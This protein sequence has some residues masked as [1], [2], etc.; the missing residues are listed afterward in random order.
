MLTTNNTV[1]EI[2]EHL[3]ALGIEYPESATKS[4]LLELV[5]A[6]EAAEEPAPEPAPKPKPEAPRFTKEELVGLSSGAMKTWFICALKKKRTYTYQ[7]AL[8]AVDEF[9]KGMFI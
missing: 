2:K 8:A 7:E 4:Q 6:D 9:K 5:P 1:K 3:D